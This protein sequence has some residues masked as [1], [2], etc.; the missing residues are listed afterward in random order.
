MMAGF[1]AAK[2]VVKERLKEGGKYNGG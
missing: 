1:R 2:A